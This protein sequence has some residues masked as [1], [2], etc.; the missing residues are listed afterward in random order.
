MAGFVGE[1]REATESDK[2]EARERR[3]GVLALEFAFAIEFAVVELVDCRDGDWGWF[4]LFREK[5]E[6]T[7]ARPR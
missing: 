4:S 2:E 1:V 3:R 7:A 6:S 5:A